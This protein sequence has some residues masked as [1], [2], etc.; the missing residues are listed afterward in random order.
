MKS[1]LFAAAVA[2]GIAAV[3]TSAQAQTAG[4]VDLGYGRMELDAGAVGK[5]SA[6]LIRLGGEVSFDSG[7]GIDAQVDGSVTR[8]ESG[9]DATVWSGTVHLNGKLVGGVRAGGFAGATVGEDL[10]LW[11]VGVEGQAN[12]GPATLVSAQLGYGKVKDLGDLDFWAGRAELRHFVTDNFKLQGSAGLTK[13]DV[14]GANLDFWNLG[15]EAEYQFSG[16]P[17]SVVGGYEHGEIKDV[18]LS[19]DTFRLGVRY[20][21]GGTLRQRDQ[22]G[23]LGSV[24]NLFGGTLGQSVIGAV[25]SIAP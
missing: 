9:G 1:Q 18:D 15:A 2:V 7:G 24:S 20:N 11:A 6:D 22:A 3:A 16:T 12:L 23:S 19:N 17:W 13:A 8:F 25:G 21:F 14:A 5:A 10:T 4:S